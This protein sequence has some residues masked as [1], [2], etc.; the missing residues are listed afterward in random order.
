M[1]MSLET[2]DSFA[3]LTDRA[4]AKTY[5]FYGMIFVLIAVAS[6]AVVMLRQ[7]LHA[8]YGAHVLSLFLYTAHLDG[9]AFEYLWPRYPAFN[10]KAS[11][12]IGSGVMIFGALFAIVF[13]QKPPP[14][15]GDASDPAGGCG[16]GSGA[17][18]RA[19]GL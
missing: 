14:S 13:L 10:N 16:R 11:V 7:A 8:I 1:A 2:A 4:N 3:A 12:V 18:Y 5:A 19:L 9:T 6:I 17:G 15:P